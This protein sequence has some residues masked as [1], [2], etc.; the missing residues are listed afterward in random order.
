MVISRI[1][2]WGFRD[3]LQNQ[4][5][6]TDP[7]EYW[8]VLE[9]VHTHFLRRFA[10]TINQVSTHAGMVRLLLTAALLALSLASF[11]WGQVQAQSG[12]HNRRKVFYRSN[13]AAGDQLHQLNQK[14]RQG[15]HQTCSS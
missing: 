15:E 10:M 8:V 13:R 6:L 1:A 14:E 2:F 5:R 7:T 3:R 12:Q 4:T 11:N 9:K